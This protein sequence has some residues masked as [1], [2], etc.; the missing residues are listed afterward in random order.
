MKKMIL[1]ERDEQDDR[2]L[3]K[4]RTSKKSLGEFILKLFCVYYV[5]FLVL[6]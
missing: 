1:W 5:K 2:L 3:Y 4:F 6:G